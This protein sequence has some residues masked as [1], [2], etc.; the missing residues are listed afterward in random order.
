MKML[1]ERLSILK[2]WIPKG[3][4]L[5]D[6]G[7]DHGFL[8]I[9]A[10]QSGIVKE[11]IAVDRSHAPIESAKRNSSRFAKDMASLSFV[12]SDGFSNVAVPRDSVVSIAGMGGRQMLRILQNAP[13]HSISRLLLQPN[14][15]SHCV[16]NWLSLN[17][18]STY[19][20]HVLEEKG[21]FFLSAQK[22]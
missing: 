19:V 3:S 18:W 6:I 5:I 16:R 13:M 7:C 21:R 11:A 15:D 22:E 2:S 10:V 8:P 14:R 4:T 17:G 12:L 9:F 20:A 1:P